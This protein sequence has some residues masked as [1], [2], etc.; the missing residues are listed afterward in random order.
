MHTSYTNSECTKLCLRLVGGHKFMAISSH[1][2][3]SQMPPMNP[4]SHGL[5]DHSFYSSHPW[6]SDLYQMKLVKECIN[7]A[8][9]QKK[10]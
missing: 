5:K 10:S 1:L 7:C 8:G 4:L 9:C 2:L 6:K 3:P